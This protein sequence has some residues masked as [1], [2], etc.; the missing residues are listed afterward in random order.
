MK[1]NYSNEVIDNYNFSSIYKI[2][3]FQKLANTNKTQVTLYA[4]LFDEGI[5]YLN[6]LKLVLIIKLSINF[7]TSQ[8]FYF[9][10]TLTHNYPHLTEVI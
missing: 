7:G 4:F 8:S 5:C 9:E 2:L 1:S 3:D 6:N 10:D